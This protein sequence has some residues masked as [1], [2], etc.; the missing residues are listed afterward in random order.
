MQNPDLLNYAARTGESITITID[1][2]QQGGIVQE[3][4]NIILDCTE[5][6]SNYPGGNISWYKYPFRDLDHTDVGIRIFQDSNILN[7][8][9]IPRVRIYGDSH[10]IYEIVRSL[11]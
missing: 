1:S 5:W 7:S 6:L 8:A 2:E 10:E 9:L 4:V 3:S 11:V